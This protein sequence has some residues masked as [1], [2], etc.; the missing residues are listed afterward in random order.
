MKCNNCGFDREL[1]ASLYCTD[2]GAPFY[3]VEPDDKFFYMDRGRVV[4]RLQIQNQGVFTL[5]PLRLI[6]A[7]T[8]NTLYSFSERWIT[9]GASQ[10]IPFEMD[11]L[12][13]KPEE[14]ETFLE[15]E[16]NGR[17]N[18]FLLKPFRIYPRPK[19]E[20][21]FG[22]IKPAK[23]SVDEE[24]SVLR[25]GPT[26]GYEIQVNLF[27]KNQSYIFIKQAKLQDISGDAVLFNQEL[28][29]ELCFNETRTTH[30]R[31]R[32]PPDRQGAVKY[33]VTLEIGKTGKAKEE[34][35]LS[36]EYLELPTPEV[37]IFGPTRLGYIY[38][39]H[40]QTDLP[41]LL[42]RSKLKKLNPP[43]R[44]LLE[45][46]DYLKKTLTALEQGCLSFTVPQAAPRQKT[47]RILA[48]TD[49]KPE[50]NF[51]DLEYTLKIEDFSAEE[52]R[53]PAQKFR[54]LAN[55]PN[56][57]QLQ[58]QVLASKT[59]KLNICCKDLRQANQQKIFSYDFK[60]TTFAAEAYDLPLG[61]DFGTTNTCLAMTLP[62][63]D[64]ENY[65][66]KVSA[67]PS[68]VILLPLD[69]YQAGNESDARIVPTL[70]QVLKEGIQLGTKADIQSN[71][72]LEN[73][74][75]RLNVKSI[76]LTLP[77]QGKM[78]VS[79]LK[80]ISDFLHELIRRTQEFL[81]ERG[82]PRC[83]INWLTATVP[84]SF[85]PA[86]RER[87]LDCC[88]DAL[89][90]LNENSQDKD[91]TLLDES[92]AALIFE[93]MVG[94]AVPLDQ[95]IIIVVYDFGGGT[96]DL[97]AVY[98]APPPEGGQPLLTELAISGDTLG[99]SHLN[100]H[101]SAVLKQLGEVQPEDRRE[102][103]YLKVEPIKRH[104][105]SMSEKE[106]QER[107]SIC[108]KNHE[109]FRP[110]AQV[111]KELHENLLNWVQVGAQRLLHD[112][113]EKIIKRL[114]AVMSGPNKQIP[115]YI[116]LAGN[117]SRLTGFQDLIIKIAQQWLDKNA[118]QLFGFN[119][120]QVV[121]L[122]EPKAC[123]AKGAFIIC[124]SEVEVER[125]Y[126]PHYSYLYQMT[127][128]A[129]SPRHLKIIPFNNIRY[130]VLNEEGC[131]FS[132]TQTFRLTDLGLK[133]GSKQYHL[134]I[135]IKQGTK[136]SPVDTFIIK[137]TTEKATSLIARLD[138]FGKLELEIN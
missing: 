82:I 33:C 111:Q 6:H 57:H 5:K 88:Y 83:E 3:I 116:L 117:S 42:T 135:S 74:K 70:I 8:D 118:R 97:T 19:L 136:I 39:G 103:E 106:L 81:E 32:L 128:L 15:F 20:W 101:L 138:D 46:D 126:L 137:P 24:K 50:Q 78:A 16:L 80:I 132:T 28:N 99:G 7:R 115:L 133:A 92:H 11:W 96:S 56:D 58:L 120:K 44:T 2:C 14:L 89:N 53:L 13:T 104:L 61:L 43:E 31:L 18:R 48:A 67:L 4:L 125:P 25:V 36:V 107:L 52:I 75:L 26:R 102:F 73:L 114:P 1:E 55:S 63:F 54:A 110:P 64:A 9:A 60:V 119:E 122:Q 47:I 109:K 86:D 68:E 34:K 40:S 62:Q 65:Q 77:D 112:L 100:Q 129:V 30:F 38:I 87:F 22:E 121:L 59:G 84:T 23:T 49:N 17:Q 72:T 108:Q 90:R 105:G 66:W 85:V 35:V 41:S 79:P 95:P 51:D 27:L 124:G 37:L 12:I 131:G 98:S 45:Q 10:I 21:S 123:V 113:F 29:L 93:R 69:T 130:V 134:P 94:H 76:E 127:P 91:V 71:Q